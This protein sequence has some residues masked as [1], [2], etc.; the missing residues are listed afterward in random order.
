MFK[1]VKPHIILN[2]N[3]IYYIFVTW[4]GNSF[5]QCYAGCPKSLR[6]MET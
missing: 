6:F 5:L 3:E 2:V 1:N 4:V